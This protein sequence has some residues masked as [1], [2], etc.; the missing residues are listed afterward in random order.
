M[1]IDWEAQWARHAPNFQDGFVSVSV[2]GKTFRLKPGPG[3]GD[4]SHPTTRLMLELL[5]QEISLPVIDIGCGSGVLSLAAC[6][7]GAPEVYGIDIEEEALAH[8]R[9][10]AALNHLPVTFGDVLPKIP[11]PCMVLMNMI[12]SEQRVAWETQRALHPHVEMMIVS[13]V[14]AQ[15][16]MRFLKTVPYGKVLTEIKLEKWMGWVFKP[17]S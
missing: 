1:T 4:L 10:N 8:A 12:S 2:H 9:I 3:F 11:S 15:E 13:G 16:K 17:R 5:P 14:P 6:A 7:L